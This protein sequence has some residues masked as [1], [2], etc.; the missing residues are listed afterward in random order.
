[1]YRI[2]I[3]DDE[4][5]IRE[6]LRKIIDWDEHG[7]EIV[8]EASNGMEAL[9][10]FNV[11]KPDILLTD[12]KMPL[13]DG[14]KLIKSV[15]EVS[16]RTKIIII[17]GFNDF[18][19]VKEALKYGVE[20]YIIKPISKEELS[21]TLVSAVEKIQ[22]ETYE[23]IKSREKEYVFRDSILYRLVTNR[24]GKRELEKKSD[25]LGM[26]RKDS[27]FSVA[28][29][30]AL[31]PEGNST[32]IAINDS[33]LFGSAMV[34]ILSE[35]ICKEVN[36]NIFIDL[37]GD[38]VAIFHSDT[39]S[40]VVEGIDVLLKKCINNI[41][42]YLR[43]DVFVAVGNV[44]EGIE[45]VHISYKTAADLLHYFVV[46]PHNHILNSEKSELENK[47]S[48]ESIIDHDHLKDMILTDR[49]DEISNYFNM[50]SENLSKS[51]SLSMKYINTFT[52]E[53]LTC[54]INTVKD[55]FMDTDGILQKYEEIFSDLLK[56]KMPEDL[57]ASA[58]NVA[59][60]L[61]DTIRQNR[62][63]PQSLIDQIIEYVN[64][65][66]FDQDLSLK[67]LSNRFDFAA[68][69]L[70]QL[71]KKKTGELFSDYVNGVRV[72]HAKALLLN[73]D[74]KASEI[75]EKV[76]Y[77]TSNYFYRIF[78]KITGAYPSEYR[79]IS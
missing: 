8:G 71:L 13:F 68:G 47:K 67:T 4:Q 1:M 78:K 75:A 37:N 64:N 62:E 9:E 42:Y 12:I 10:A 15:R 76:G 19:Y 41:N 2:L 38:A 49:S 77:S 53:L 18:Q 63:N 39:K 44:Q 72:E 14:L 16:S 29:I 51:T 48:H 50:L 26:D 61:A 69:Y 65:N 45:N 33:S 11:L 58:K 73:T 21:S 24:I 6:G 30:K 70:G 7:L 74:M 56:Q 79:D 59:L 17:S 22:S 52:V 31:K 23:S 40:G 54:L 27:F 66:Y 35:T 28:I 60:E 5:L 36:C 55:A 32:D 25:L 43:S 34:N 20:N 3:V 46:F 57:V